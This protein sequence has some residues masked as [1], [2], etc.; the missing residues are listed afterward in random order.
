MKLRE[1]QHMA[2]TIGIAI[3]RIR[4][5]KHIILYVSKDERTMVL[6][7]S[8]TGSCPWFEKNVLADMKR[9]ARGN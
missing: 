2:N 9:F 7:I 3:D 8:K 5:G 6:T 4:I 1:L